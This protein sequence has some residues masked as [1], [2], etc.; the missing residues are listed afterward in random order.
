MAHLFPLCLLF[1]NDKADI[2]NFISWHKG[3]TYVPQQKRCRHCLVKPAAFH[4]HRPPIPDYAAEL[5]ISDY[6]LILN[7]VIVR[8]YCFTTCNIYGL[9]E[10][11]VY[12][13][14]SQLS[15]W[16]HY[17]LGFTE[18][19]ENLFISKDVTTGTAPILPDSTSSQIL[20]EN[21]PQIPRARKDLGKQKC[22]CF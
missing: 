19:P 3:A 22:N 2:L 7:C 4:N 13:V 12:N 16:V 6:C 8:A 17:T 15:W 14:R 9:A 20:E 18:P 1:I 10:T 21:W 11:R 5:D